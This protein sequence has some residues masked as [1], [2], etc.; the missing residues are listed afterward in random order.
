MNRLSFKHSLSR[1]T[2]LHQVPRLRL[3][4]GAALHK[5]NVWCKL[6][7]HTGQTRMTHVLQLSIF[8]ASQVMDPLKLITLRHPTGKSAGTI[9]QCDYL[10]LCDFVMDK[11]REAKTISLIG[12]IDAVENH[13]KNRKDING[14]FRWMTLAIKLNLEAQGL[15]TTD[16]PKGRE[17]S[18]PLLR[19]KSAKTRARAKSSTF[20]HRTTT[21]FNDQS[22]VSHDR[23]YPF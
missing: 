11:I 16:Y 15:I 23:G 1:G 10:A 13:F 19:L 14:D 21:H 4:R 20:H 17:R 12:L 7:R 8:T 9:R 6:T 18:R 2:L 5:H 3:R 22:M